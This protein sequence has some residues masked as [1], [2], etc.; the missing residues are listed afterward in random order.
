[1]SKQLSE[2]IK[3]FNQCQT[4]YDRTTMEIGQLYADFNRTNDERI[5]T[6][7]NSKFEVL[8]KVEQRLRELEKEITDNKN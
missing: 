3:E 8:K 7:L 2:I 5:K 1:M 6:S 4:L